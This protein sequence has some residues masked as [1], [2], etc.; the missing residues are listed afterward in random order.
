MVPPR[1]DD[2]I[3]HTDMESRLLRV[4]ETLAEEVH[5]GENPP[6]KLGPLTQFER[7][8]GFDSLMR[9]ELLGRIEHTLNVR[10]P[11]DAFASSAT[12]A[13]VLRAIET[14]CAAPPRQ[15]TDGGARH[16]PFDAIG[17]PLQ[18]Q[19]LIYAL[20]W[21]VDRHPDRTHIFVVEDGVTSSPLTYGELYRRAARAASGLRSVGIDP[22]DTVALM[23]P[24]GC[25]YFVSF[26]GI[27]LCGAIPVPIYPP[28]RLSQVEEHVRR[29]AAILANAQVKA[30]ITVPQAVVVAR[31]LRALVP[32]V[33]QVLTPASIDG[34]EPG[35]LFAPRAEDTAFLQ[36]TSGST[37]DPK[38]VVLSH[39]NLL[40]NIRA[41]GDRMHVD[42]SDVL[43]SWLPLYHD[44][45]LIGAWFA[46]MY[47]GFPLVVM[48][49]T[50]FLARPERWLQLF[51]RYRGTITAAPNF[52]YE[53][54]ARHIDDA[55]L[56]G[57]DLSSLRFAFCGAE[58]VSRPY[59]ACIAEH[60]A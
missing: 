8:L 10:L 18:A 22:G 51:Q 50:T 44:M 5:S 55:D 48:S 34:S 54:C 43:V 3:H 37:G 47:Y 2:V 9:A 25:D 35:A 60:D 39:G 33:D 57:L 31:L 24:T 26:L 4:V 11:V 32:S 41:M 42:A 38:G 27:M 49:P 36:Y 21:H 30:L 53:R 59:P 58:P 45:G 19:T 13:D 23:L 20:R 17:A 7:D 46:P 15:P 52:A 14:D 28:A 6:V 12:P 1:V 56:D 40:A 16:M 29:H